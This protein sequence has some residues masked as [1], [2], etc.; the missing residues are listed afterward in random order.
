MS[1][2]LLHPD[3]KDTPYW[4][5]AAPP[6]DRGDADPPAQADFVAFAFDF[7]FPCEISLVV[8]F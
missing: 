3:F 7:L 2:D 5:E 1:D 4:W 6:S 8:L